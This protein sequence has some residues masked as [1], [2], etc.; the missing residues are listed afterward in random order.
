M[1]RGQFLK[2]KKI[3]GVFFASLLLILSAC[4]S[5][6]HKVNTHKVNTT[7]S[8]VKKL[9]GTN[10]KQNNYLFFNEAEPVKQITLSFY[11]NYDKK[12]IT[13]I[14][15]Y[16]GTQLV[17]NNT[18]ILDDSIHDGG[19]FNFQ[20]KSYVKS[21]DMVEFENSDG[22]LFKLHT[23][24][25]TFEKINIKNEINENNRWQLDGFHTNE[26]SFSFRIESKFSRKAYIKDSIELLNANK[27]QQKPF[28]I[29]EKS[30]FGEQKQSFDFSYEMKSNQK[31]VGSYELILLQK[32]ATKQ[33]VLNSIV[34]PI[35]P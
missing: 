13:K 14:N 3:L 31:D 35:G 32:D 10:E 21:F 20:L 1:N 4:N 30:H 33:N 5:K 18:L 28:I 25:Y 2:N 15:L 26:D 6:T 16:K 8:I 7:Q 22:P 24:N 34:V 9:E 27:N 29:K 17:S 11:G 19:K 23:G 12:K